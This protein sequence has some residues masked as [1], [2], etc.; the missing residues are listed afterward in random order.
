MC[1]NGKSR[2]D[3]DRSGACCV[4]RIHATPTEGGGSNSERFLIDERYVE[5]AVRNSSAGMPRPNNGKSFAS[6]DLSEVRA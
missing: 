1:V 5:T 3:G 6:S 4:V 2:L